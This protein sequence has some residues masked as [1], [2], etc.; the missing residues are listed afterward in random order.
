[1]SPLFIAGLPTFAAQHAPDVAVTLA[2]AALATALPRAVPSL[3]LLAIGFQSV[4]TRTF[5][6]DAEVLIGLLAGL[7]IVRARARDWRMPALGAAG[8]LLLALNAMVVVSL[9]AHVRSSDANAIRLATE[10]FVS[11]SLLVAAV[12]LLARPGRPRAWMA[13]VGL[14]AVALGAAR[15]LEAFGV[16][17]RST[18]S[19]AGIPLLGDYDDPGSWN[20]YA[21][22]L[23]V[24]VACL[25]ALGLERGRP[26]G[27]AVMLIGGL[28]FTTMAMASAQS[29][30]AVG[31]FAVE[32][33][34]LLWWAHG[35][36]RRLVVLGIA[37]AFAVASLSPTFGIQHK[38]V[39]VSTEGL[40]DSQKVATIDVPIKVAPNGH[41]PTPGSDGATS[42]P[43]EPLPALQPDWRSVLDR[44]YYI[45][46]QTI[47]ADAFGVTGNRIEFVGRSGGHPSRIRLMVKFEGHEVAEI[48]PTQMSAAYR[49]VE[50][51][52]PDDL[53][54]RGHPGKVS[55]SVSGDP[56][57]F[58][59]FFVVAGRNAHARG[60]DARI[61]SGTA[62]LTDDLSDDVGLQQGMLLVVANEHVP[63]MAAFKPNTAPVVDPSIS[64][65][66]FLWR[67]AINVF[68][69]NPIAGTGFYTFGLVKTQFQPPAPVFAAYSNTHSNYFE[70][71]AD[72]GAA[73]PVLFGLL[74]LVPLGAL[75]LTRRRRPLTAVEAG[76]GLSLFA[77]AA[78]SLTQT[79]MADSR[80]Y[81]TCW[82]LALVACSVVGQGSIAP[83]EA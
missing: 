10:Y 39:L 44:N 54:P 43:R 30:T 81:M 73:G 48:S 15:A 8:W 22:V 16:P 57:S 69:H 45:L 27:W 63:D 52:I 3:A 65:R 25:A 40:P 64:D 32:V 50:I 6:S 19:G 79:W 4:L 33:V 55:F 13:A 62:W 36:L 23:A 78:S 49:W 9:I 83:D 2:A 66:L 74:L 12:V 42:P 56:D 21:T 26:R 14:L 35:L 41:L 61:W 71:L 76:L 29:R 31:I 75:A 47:P 51:P 7:L 46:E 18:L 37:A 11:R 60:Y 34:V 67:T 38:P 5:N 24:G 80:V 58:S 70:L 1:M 17:V 53:V 72:I 28:A 59:N 20:T 82:L 68:L 77:F